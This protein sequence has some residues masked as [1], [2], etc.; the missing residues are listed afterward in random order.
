MSFKFLKIIFKLT[1]KIKKILS[2]N[3]KK[4]SKKESS[5][6]QSNTFL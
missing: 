2:L 6:L 5:K 3:N 4:F 1:N